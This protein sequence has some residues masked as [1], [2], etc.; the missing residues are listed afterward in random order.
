MQ[1]PYVYNNYQ[2]YSPPLGESQ[3]STSPTFPAS[4]LNGSNNSGSSVSSASS[5]SPNVGSNYLLQNHR[6]RYY[7]SKSFDAEDDLEFCPNIPEHSSNGSPMIKKFNPYTASFFS[8]TATSE[9]Q[10]MNS[11]TPRARTPIRKPLEIV[12]QHSKMRVGSPAATN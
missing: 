1:N 11:L 9:H 12:N 8:P 2:Q 6:L 3:I 7:L 4:Y 10:P 5:T